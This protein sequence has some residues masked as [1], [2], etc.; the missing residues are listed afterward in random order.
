M[1]REGL[2]CAITALS[3]ELLSHVGAQQENG[4][5]HRAPQHRELLKRAVRDLIALSEE[6][7]RHGET[8]VKSHMFLC[9]ILAQV[10]AVEAGLGVELAIA[11]SATDSLRFCHGIL[12]A[13]AEASLPVE[14]LE[15]VGAMEGLDGA[16]PGSM[17]FESYGMDGDWDWDSFLPAVGSS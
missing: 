10:E 1:F 8:N 16:T 9:M 4:T 3:L 5:L 17:G 11:R 15:F 13:R 2:R 7:I 12:N 14:E 6:R